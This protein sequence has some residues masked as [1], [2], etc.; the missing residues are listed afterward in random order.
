[1]VVS[2]SIQIKIYSTIIAAIPIC[3]VFN[4]WEGLFDRQR[5]SSIISVA[6]LTAFFGLFI[7]SMIKKRF[8]QIRIPDV[9]IVAYSL[10]AFS[11]NLVGFNINQLGDIIS[12]LIYIYIRFARHFDYRYL[13]ATVLFSSLTLSFYGYL[14]YFGVLPTFHEDY[15]ITGPF[16]NPAPYGALICFFISIMTTIATENFQKCYRYTSFIF[17]CFSM[18]ALILSNSRA[19]WMACLI[20]T[21]III[22]SKYKIRIRNF[23]NLKRNILNISIFFIFII[24][25]L[26]FYHIRP[27]SVKGR[28]F[29]WKI[30]SEMIIANPV[31]GT[32][33][34]GVQAN[35]MNYQYEYFK[36]EK[37]NDTEKSLAGNVVSVY[38]EPIRIMIE[39]GLVGFI[40]YVLII[41]FVLFRTTTLSAISLAAKMVIL[42]Y[43]IFGMFS[44][45]NRV[46]SLQVV[47]IIALA[48]LLNEQKR[49]AKTL[50][51]SKFRQIIA[52][53]IFITISL[54]LF[55]TV[56]LFHYSY[57]KFQ[58]ILKNRPIEISYN[59]NNLNFVITNDYLLLV[60]YCIIVK[61]IAEENLLLEKLNK[62]ILLSPSSILYRMKGDYLYQKEDYIEAEKAYW[63][64]HYMVPSNLLMQI[65]LVRLYVRLNKITEAKKLARS[66]LQEKAKSNGIDTFVLRLE[67]QQIISDY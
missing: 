28:V 45:P 1:M 24:L 59:L 52:K 46:F 58:C 62:A 31:T 38:N 67:M 60:N 49:C 25:G 3:L 61:D 15:S 32:G 36:Q 27:D 5:T 13:Y 66:F 17:I 18:P 19:A 41:Y 21:T 2:K 10:F 56:I 63:K 39:Y 51:I 53:N 50:Y 11:R 65:K 40:L 16:Y 29:I 55:V 7:F 23:S 47:L 14:Q 42:T 43:I 54:L 33:Y 9:L 35:Y 34:N 12:I 22:V 4:L 37:G 30:A 6:Y 8:L 26:S 57:Q 64:A 48:C 20:T 44:Y